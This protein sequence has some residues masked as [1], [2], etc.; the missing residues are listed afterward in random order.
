MWKI[1]LKSSPIEL[2]T[3]TQNLIHYWMLFVFLFRVLNT[4]YVEK[5]IIMK[6]QNGKI[7]TQIFPSFSRSL[8]C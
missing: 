1:E 2:P 5:N 6:A 7:H 4:V 8:F 3:A